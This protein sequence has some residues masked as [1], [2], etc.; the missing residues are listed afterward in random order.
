MFLK[1]L[2]IIENKDIIASIFR[3][4][5]YD[6]IMCGYF[7][8]EFIDFMLDGKSLIDFT[9]LFSPRDFKKNDRIIT[10]L[11]K[12]SKYIVTFDYADKIFI[13]LSASFGT[14]SIVSQ[15]TIVGIPVGIARSSLTLIFTVTTGIVKKKVKYYKKKEEKAQ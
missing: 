3:L 12:I 9:N 7:C 11:F 10:K 14:L 1:K 8:I 6:S 2:K 15:A 5:A 4:Q 13:T